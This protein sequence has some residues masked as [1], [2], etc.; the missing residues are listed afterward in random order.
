MRWYQLGEEILG[1]HQPGQPLCGSLNACPTRGLTKT[2]PYRGAEWIPQQEL[3][4]GGPPSGPDACMLRVSADRAA[5]CP[6]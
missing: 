3:H 6:D 2:L 1:P 4:L 5:L